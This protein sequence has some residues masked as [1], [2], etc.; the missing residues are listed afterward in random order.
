MHRPCFKKK[1]Y[2]GLWKRSSSSLLEMNAWVPDSTPDMTMAD[3]ETISDGFPNS[4]IISRLYLPMQE[5]ICFLCLMFLR[6]AGAL[7]VRS[8]ANLFEP[9]EAM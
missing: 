1:R 3:S 6:S 8:L 5:A 7:R 9:I 2:P 4:A